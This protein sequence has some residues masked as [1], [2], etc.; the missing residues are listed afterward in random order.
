VAALKKKEEE[1]HD[2]AEGGSIADWGGQMSTTYMEGY[3]RRSNCRKK[4]GGRQAASAW[5]KGRGGKKRGCRVEKEKERKRFASSR[6][7]IRCWGGPWADVSS[8]EKEK[9]PL[10][11]G[12]CKG[13][14]K[15]GSDEGESDPSEKSSARQGPRKTCAI[16]SRGGGDD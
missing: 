4:T 6:E 13:E 10:Q 12:G 5:C 1:I 11:K 8:L 16:I 3:R 15:K 9:E 7:A 14:K 2:G